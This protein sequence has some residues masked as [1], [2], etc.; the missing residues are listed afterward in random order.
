[1]LKVVELK[2]LKVHNLTGAFWGC[3][4]FSNKDLNGDPDPNECIFTL[5]KSFYLELNPAVSLLSDDTK[6]MSL[7]DWFKIVSPDKRWTIITPHTNKYIDRVCWQWKPTKHGFPR[8]WKPVSVADI[9]IFV[10]ITLVLAK[11]YIH[12]SG[13]HWKRCEFLKIKTLISG[14]IGGSRT[15]AEDK[16]IPLSER[17]ILTKLMVQMCLQ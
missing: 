13:D 14:T 17:S 9:K 12:A 5:L 3:G 16:Y 1:M 10:A 7:L 15:G 4:V 2:V 8:R 6:K 11:Y